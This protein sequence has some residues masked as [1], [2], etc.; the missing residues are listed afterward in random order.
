MYASKVKQ[1][2]APE[3]L[4]ETEASGAEGQEQAKTQ[5][6][7]SDSIKQK[8]RK[9]NLDRRVE[10]IE[11]RTGGTAEYKGPARRE[12]IDRRDSASDRRDED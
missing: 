2:V 11:R 4:K 10:G 5:R 9:L 3:N 6:R 1:D 7:L 12:V 8:G